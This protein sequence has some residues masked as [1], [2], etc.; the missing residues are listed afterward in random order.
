MHEDMRDHE[1]GSHRWKG[2]RCQNVLSRARGCE[3]RQAESIDVQDEE[4]K[5]EEVWVNSPV[6]LTVIK[7]YIAMN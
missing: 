1:P 6:H 7:P 3:T 5:L 2:H 4:F